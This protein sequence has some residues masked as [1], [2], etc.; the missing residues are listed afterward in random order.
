[1]KP[2]HMRVILKKSLQR[3]HFDDSLYQVHSFRIGR[4]M[5]LLKAGVSVETIRKLGWWKSNIV[6]RYLRV[7]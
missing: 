2:E 3:A 1:M 7:F 4:S 6:Y 5:D